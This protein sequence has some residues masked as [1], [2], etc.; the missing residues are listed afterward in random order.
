VDHL[1][2]ATFRRVLVLSV[3]GLS[4]LCHNSSWAKCLKVV[5]ACTE[6][7][8]NEVIERPHLNPNQ[9]LINC[10]AASTARG[11]ATKTT[12]KTRIY[13]DLPKQVASKRFKEPTNRYCPAMGKRIFADLEPICNDVSGG[14]KATHDYSARLRPAQ[15]CRLDQKS[16]RGQLVKLIKQVKVGD[17]RQ[18]VNVLFADYSPA[19]FAGSPCNERAR[20]MCIYGHPG[21]V[22]VVPLN[23]QGRVRR[24]PQLRRVP[25]KRFAARDRQKTE[26]HP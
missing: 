4:L 9:Y 6:V 12:K 5:Y 23:D 21:W 26:T 18:Q 1:Y 19:N 14:K 3:L 16:Q 24:K 20:A 10:T 8:P 2:Q 22:V 15:V 11:F 13:F 25:F 17:R 7:M